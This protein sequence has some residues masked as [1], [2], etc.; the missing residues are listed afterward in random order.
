MDLGAN[1][2]AF[3]VLMATRADFVLSVEAQEHFVPVIQHNMQK[4]GYTNYAIE[5]GFVGTGGVLEKSDATPLA[6]QQ[7]MNRHNLKQVDLIKIDIEGS[8]FALFALPDWLQRVNAISMEVH[9]SHG[10]PNIIIESLKKHGFIFS[11]GDENLNCMTDVKRASFI[12]ARR[13]A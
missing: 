5:V 7:L 2:G 6:I 1:R 10:D 9:T 13:K 4:N 3:S 8:E 12:Y 11:I